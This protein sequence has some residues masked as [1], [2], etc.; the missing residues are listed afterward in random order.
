[1]FAKSFRTVS[2]FTAVARR[3]YADVAGG[4]KVSVAMPHDTLLAN[5]AVTQVNVPGVSG[6][7]GILADHVPIVEQ[8]K[9]G[10]VEVIEGTTSTKYFI[11]GGFVSVLPDSKVSIT[12]PE[13]FPLEAF[14]ATSV[15]SLLAEAV[16]N[17]AS[18]DEKIAAEASIEV[19]VL[20]ALSAALH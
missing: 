16:K 11:S 5:K 15:K 10:L 19:E 3:S 12:T 18:A 8:L 9:P 13:A 20:E 6:D 17:S 14:D 1:M 2:K 4:L 7:M